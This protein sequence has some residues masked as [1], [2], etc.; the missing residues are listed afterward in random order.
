MRIL[1]LAVAAILGWAA[2]AAG[3]T[4]GLKPGEECERGGCTATQT[5]T[6]IAASGEANRLAI[7]WAGPDVVI[8]DDA[9]PVAPGPGCRGLDPATVACPIANGLEVDTG[10]A[11]DAA[12]VMAFP[13]TVRPALVSL[14]PGDDRFTGT[15]R[16]SGGDGHDTMAAGDARVVFDGGAG[17]DVLLG[18]AAGDALLGG[19][20]ADT[21][22][23]GAGDDSLD[24]A[25]VPV[26][27]RGRPRAAQPAADVADGGPGSDGLSYYPRTTAV[28]V[29]LADGRPEGGVGEADVA[30]GI[31][32]VQGGFG[33][34]RLAGDDGPNRLSSGGLADSDEL[35]GRGGDD[36]LDGA[37]G[38]DARTVMRG[39]A[40]DDALNAYGSARLLDAGPGDDRVVALFNAA[41]VRC[42]DGTDVLRADFF[43][44]APP[45]GLR[46]DRC[47]RVAL[48]DGLVLTLPGDAG[49]QR[50][51]FGVACPVRVQAA[52]CR[53]RVTV[54]DAAGRRLGTASR[55]VAPGRTGRLTTVNRPATPGRGDLRVETVIARA[56]PGVRFPP[57]V[58]FGARLTRTRD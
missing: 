34:D 20:G 23:G 7:T 3:A 53:A 41:L 28:V 22:R 27:S 4:F 33:D 39:G 37:S 24:V 40:G 14:G 13:S 32:N 19:T 11:E 21:L 50:T 16:V 56:R 8:H 30:R 9:A 49:A 48:S 26:D 17:D 51:T 46:L 29:D 12:D 36:V 2:P 54:R 52:R 15:A 35:V 42:G 43:E 55:A 18:G 44:L 47:E 6:F 57:P 5:A 45:A 25:D 58:R 31:E 10:D 38:L 1:L